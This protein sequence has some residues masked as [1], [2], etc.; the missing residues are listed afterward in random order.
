MYHLHHTTTMS[1]C[2]YNRRVSQ[3]C[4]LLLRTDTISVP[5][6]CY[7]PAAALNTKTT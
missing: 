2:V 3:R 5:E 1:V 4:I 7:L 6:F